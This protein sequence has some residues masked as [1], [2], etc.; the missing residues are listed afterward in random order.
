MEN[1]A[2]IGECLFR[3]GRFRLGSDQIFADLLV[4]FEQEKTLP[5]SLF[6]RFPLRDF[7]APLQQSQPSRQ[8]TTQPETEHRLPDRVQKAL[9]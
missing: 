9:N 3:N 4:L 6:L 1:L 8:A 2:F 7:E 5:A